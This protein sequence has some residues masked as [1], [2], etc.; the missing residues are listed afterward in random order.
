MLAVVNQIN[1]ATITANSTVLIEYPHSLSYQDKTLIMLPSTTWVERESTIEERGLPLKSIETNGRSLTPK[2]PL[3]S[4][5][6]YSF[7]APLISSTVAGFFNSATRSVIET[8]GVG[9]RIERP[10]NFPF[11]SGIT[12]PI[13]FA[14]PVEVG[15]IDNAA[16]RALRRSLW[17]TSNRFWSLVYAWIVVISPRTTPNFSFKTLT[18]GARQFVVQEA[19]EIKMCS[20]FNFPQLTPRTTVKSRSFPGAETMTRFAPA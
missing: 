19:F 4:P 12:S 11:N 13:A 15:I 1:P 18:I 20:F 7:R 2:I 10:F 14:A 16:A 8:V 6:A 5:S 17:L 3:S 9:T